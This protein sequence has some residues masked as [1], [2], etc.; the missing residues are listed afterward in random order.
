MTLVL[1]IAAFTIMAL[2]IRDVRPYLSEEEQI[3][4]RSWFKSWGT[5]RFDR[6]LRDAWNLH[7]QRFPNSQKRV[8]LACVFTTAVL[9]ILSFPIWKAMR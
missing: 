7:A 5:G 6:A 9:S 3:N 2:I 8:L 1:A 4:F